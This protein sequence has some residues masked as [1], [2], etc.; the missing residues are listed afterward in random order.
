MN[1]IDFIF[2]GLESRVFSCLVLAEV[3]K[4]LDKTVGLYP[5]GGRALVQPLR[6]VVRHVPV[7]FRRVAARQRRRY[8]ASEFQ[9]DALNSVEQIFAC[10]LVVAREVD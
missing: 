6:V 3:L 7:E 1:G 9:R 8:R 5:R 10:L 2:D 4:S